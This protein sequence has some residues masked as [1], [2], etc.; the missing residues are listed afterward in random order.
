MFG[1]ALMVEG[2]N[3]KKGDT[4]DKRTEILH[5]RDVSSGKRIT[6]ITKI[7][8]IRSIPYVSEQSEKILKNAGFYSLQDISKSS[9]QEI[10]ESTSLSPELITRI[11]DFALGY[12]SAEFE[13]TKIKRESLSTRVRF[14]VFKRDAFR[15]QYCGKQSG[16]GIEL[17]VDHIIPIAKGNRGKSSKEVLNHEPEKSEVPKIKEKIRRIRVR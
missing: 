9:R 2:K 12:I 13:S 3:A 7:S 10:I 8:D 14:E 11:F 16:E 4:H 6:C 5:C 1:H 15:C 17:E